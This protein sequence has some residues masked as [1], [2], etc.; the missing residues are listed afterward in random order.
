[1]NSFRRPLLFAL[2]VVI[3]IITIT[4]TQ[5]LVFA[6]PNTETIGPISETDQARTD[7]ACNYLG[8][9]D[10]MKGASFIDGYQECKAA[11][12]GYWK[13]YISGCM[14]VGNTKE[15]CIDMVHRQ[16]TRENVERNN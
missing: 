16:V 6:S 8:K 4:S 3:A 13:G 11:G 1:M 10:G 9:H 5:L 7:E 2:A 12:V 14:E 15:A